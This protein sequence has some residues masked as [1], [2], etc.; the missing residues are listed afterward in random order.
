MQQTLKLLSESNS[1]TLFLFIASVVGLMFFREYIRFLIKLKEIRQN[2][3]ESIDKT[4]SENESSQTNIEITGK[5]I[6]YNVPDSSNIVDFNFKL[7]DNYYE[8][9]LT[10][11][12]IM[13]R[14][15]LIIAV[16]GFIIVIICV[17]F[18]ISGNS[19]VSLITGIAGVITEAASFL[20]FKQNKILIDQV[21]E[22]HRKLVSTQYLLTS[23]SLAKELPE[24]E[25][26]K[27][28]RRIIGNMLFLSNQL[29]DSPSMH[30]FENSSS[31][32]KTVMP[33]DNI[34][35]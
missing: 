8:Q 27:E 35:A 30:L 25:S 12:K 28:K 20:F 2:K 26:V 29:H 31:E 3:P 13:A 24:M 9:S 15:S 23:I 18:A 22:Y 14:A 5:N 1:P 4:L 19:S 16:L 21:K 6:V 17:F 11:Y 33:E 7:L 34:T 32:E 10:E